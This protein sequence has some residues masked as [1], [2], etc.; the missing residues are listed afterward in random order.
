MVVFV[1]S[2]QLNMNLEEAHGKLAELTQNPEIFLKWVRVAHITH[3]FIPH[4]LT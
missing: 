4:F 3:F 2:N 1:P